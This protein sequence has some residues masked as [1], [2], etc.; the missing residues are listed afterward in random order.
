MSPIIRGPRPV[1]RPVK[2]VQKPSEQENKQ[3]VKPEEVKVE[4]KVEPVSE[5]KPTVENKVTVETKTVTPETKT[6]TPETKKVEQKTPPTKQAPV[7]PVKQPKPQGESKGDPLKVLLVISNLIFIGIAGYLLYDKFSSADVIAMEKET[8]TAAYKTEMNLKIT[9]I[10]RLEDS[11]RLVIKEKESLGL[12]LTEERAKLAELE[13]LKVQI[14]NKN[15]SIASLNKKL[16]GIK[17]HYAMATSAMEAMTASNKVQLQ[18][19]ESLRQMLQAKD[20]SLKLVV[21]KA[22]ELEKKVAIASSLKMESMQITAFS[23]SGKELNHSTSYKAMIVGKVKIHVNFAKND[24]A[25]GQKE[26]YLRVLEPGGA[27]LREGDKNFMVDGKKTAYTDK[28][29]ID[30]SSQHAASFFYVKGSKYRPGSYTVEVYCDGKKA[31]SG[32]L[33]LNQ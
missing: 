20:D 14:Q 11:L 12:E 2:P 32:V 15:Y 25:Q 29:S 6:V 33:T 4:T 23:T 5:T 8:T 19:E 13:D 1:M 22:E 30:A 9:E 21:T 7:K 27:V 18:E 10:N 3:E 16:A 24:I 26:I 28:Q 17:E 31:G